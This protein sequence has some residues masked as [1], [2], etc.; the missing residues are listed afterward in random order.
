MVTTATKLEDNVSALRLCEENPGKVTAF[1]MGEEGASSRLL[2]MF[3][4]APIAYAAL[5]NDAV[6]PGQLSIS[7]MI[8]FRGLV[9][10]EAG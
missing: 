1:C 10:N 7:T 6:A 4:Q 5:P 9:P 2:S 8:E 3:M